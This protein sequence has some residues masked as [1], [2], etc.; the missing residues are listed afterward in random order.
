MKFSIALL[1]IIIS[2]A[3][4]VPAADRLQL[5]ALDRR[6]LFPEGKEAAY[7]SQCLQVASVQGVDAETAVKHCKCGATAIK[8][9]FTNAEIEALDSHDRVNAKLLQR[10]Q[11]VVR[12]ACAAK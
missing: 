1:A 9:S 12:A 8:S 3:F 4:A 10:V 2:T 7:L 5:A 11:Q 6:G